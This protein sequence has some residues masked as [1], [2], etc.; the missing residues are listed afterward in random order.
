MGWIKD[1]ISPQTR[2]WEE[3]Y[4]NRFQH[5]RIV[6]STHG[7]NC[8]GGCSWQIHVKDGIVT[9]ETQQLDYPLLEDKL[10]PYEPRGCQRGISYSWYLYSPLRIKYPLVRGALLDAYRR[11]KQETGDPMRAWEALQ[12]DAQARRSYQTARGKGGFRRATWDECLEIMSVANIYTAKKYG[13]DRVIGFSPIPA[14]S[15]LSYAAG[16]RFLQL[17]GGVNLSFYDWYC[18][19]PTAF[20]EIWGEQTDVCE[21]ADWYNAKMIA[22]MGACLNMT[23]TPDCHFFAESR[24]NGTKAVVFAPDFSQVSKYAD[25][26]VPIHA[27]SDGAFWMAVTHVILKEFHHDTK[28][29]F[30]ADYVKR[31][32][33][34][35]YLVRLDKDGDRYKPGRLLRAA[36]VAALAGVRNPEWQFVNVDAKTGALVVPKGSVGSRWADKPGDWNMKLENLVDDAPYDPALSLLGSA[37]EVV[38]AAFTEFGLD[39]TVT[40]GVPAKRVPL[41]DGSTAV[42]ATVYDLIMAQYGVPRG[43]P[44]AYPKDYTD[45]DAAYT[46]AWQE[47]FT[48]VDSKTVLQF[49]REWAATAEKTGGKCMI[50][51]GAGINHWYHANLMYRAGAMALML[52][53]CVG[54]NGGGLNHYVGQEKLA[55]SDSWGAIAFAKDHHAASR[56]QQAPLWH[57]INTCQYR[58]DGQFSKYNTVPD[59]DWTQMHTADTIFKAVRCGW[60]PF[61]PQF[62]QNTLELAEEAVAAGAKDDDAVKRYVVEKLE[63]KELEYSIHDPDAPENHPRVWYIW[64]GNAIMG[65]MKGHEYCLKHYLGTHSNAIGKDAEDHPREVKWHDVAPVGKMDLVVDLNFRMDSSA[66]YSD[67][68]LPAA[69]WYEKADLNSTDLHS[70]I[71]PLSAAIP[72]VWEAKSDWS[73]FH[74]LAR[75]TSAA[76]AKYFPGTHKDIVN[77]PLSHDSAGEIAQPRVQDWFKGEC[78]PVPGKTMHNIAIE[79]RDYTQLYEKFITLGD[80]IRTAGLG[81]HGNHYQCTDAYDEMLTSNHF[82]KQKRN[83][84]AYPS[85]KEDEHAVNAVLHLSTLTNGKLNVRAYENMEKKTGMPLADLGHGTADFRITYADLQAQPRRYTTSPLWSGVMTNGRAY[86]AYTYNVEKLVPWRTLTGRQHFYLDQEMYI[87]YGEHLPTYKPSPKPEAYGDLRETLKTGEARILNCLTPHGKWHI[88]STYME[89]HRMLTLSRGCEPCWISE[90]DAEALGIKDNDWVEVYND[91]GVYCAR[92]SVSARIPKGVCI[93]YH[94]PERTVGIPKSQVRGNRRAGGHN[95]FTRVHLKPNYLNGGYGQFSYHFNYWGPIAPQ[96][97]T[98]VIVKRMD[99]VVF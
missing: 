20:P 46:P 80:R 27:G 47:I 17:F 16:S 2:K 61:Y 88:H 6:R 93:V 24:H 96:R 38:Q 68:V 29:E 65:S 48:G 90:V 44:G 59:N 55:P 99:K 78:K 66:L 3:F 34:S 74:E 70:F 21:S 98:H 81:A 91:H 13:P 12:A 5:D 76:A 28:S 82:P 57:Y 75:A 84:K 9:W 64:R 32:T 58:Y 63:S 1:I 89:N 37:D 25:Q 36:E 41:A 49:A 8:T 39:A 71:H 72:P 94:V 83:G 15:M 54:K 42:V 11:K 43:L 31:Y 79:D 77:A 73:I 4:R 97:D 7:V 69:S 92:A 19:L 52:T 60:M 62:K 95:S 26:W 30:F 53:G 67:I 18:D 14:M 86:S 51:I 40:R 85:L 35:P 23:R 10:P 87:A 45:K 22:D 33:D 56:L 50:I